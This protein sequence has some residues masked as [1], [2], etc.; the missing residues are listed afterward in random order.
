MEGAASAPLPF[1]HVTK[2]HS[3]TLH[4]TCAP[5]STR[6]DLR[7]SIPN[8]GYVQDISLYKPSSGVAGTS[9][10][11]APGKSIE[12]FDRVFDRAQGKVQFLHRSAKD[13]LL[14]RGCLDVLFEDGQA[15]RC[16]GNGHSFILEFAKAWLELP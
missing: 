10:V 13:F 1:C 5:H 11:I 2:N 16:L 7:K 8:R 14:A 6:P 9:E 15:T 3:M 4:H 12:E